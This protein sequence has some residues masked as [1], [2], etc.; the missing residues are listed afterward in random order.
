[1]NKRETIAILQVSSKWKIEINTRSFEL[2]G[3]RK[4]IERARPA[5]QL[6]R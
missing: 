1:M 4:K 5:R 3:N 6:Q 2:L